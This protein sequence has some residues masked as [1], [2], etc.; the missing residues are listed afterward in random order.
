MAECFAC[1]A[2]QASRLPDGLKMTNFFS[3]P[4]RPERAS[5]GSNQSRSI[6]ET[7]SVARLLSKSVNGSATI[8]KMGERKAAPQDAVCGWALK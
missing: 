2:Y 7:K 1:Y 4:S 5:C 3:T 8:S 6:F